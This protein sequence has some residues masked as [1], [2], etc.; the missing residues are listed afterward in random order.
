MSTDFL[1][2]GFVETITPDFGTLS[3]YERPV[4]WL[5]L[6]VITSADQ[7]FVGL[8]AV[9]EEANFAAFVANGA[10]TVDWGDGTVENYSAGATALHEYDY[11]N[12]ALNGSLCSRGYKQAVVIITP[13]AGQTLS[14]LNLFI[15]HTQ[16]GLQGYTSG[17]LDIAVAGTSISSLVISSA[18]ST[19]R[20]SLL[21]QVAIYQ[22]VITTWAN[23][24]YNCH[25]LRS[26]PVLYTNSGTDFSSMFNGCYALLTVPLFNTANGT[27]F[28]QTFYACRNLQEV[29][30]LN[31]ANGLNFANTFQN[32]TNLRRVGAWDTSKGTTFGGM[33]QGCNALLEAPMLNTALGTE[34]GSM[35]QNCYSL[36]KVPVYNTA[37]G[38]NFSQMFGTCYSLR[39]APALNTANGTQFANM[40]VNCYSLLAVPLLDTA[41]GL[42]FGSMFSSCYRL[43]EIPALNTS[44]GNSF[45][46][47]FASC[48]GLRT[49]PALDFS[50]ATTLLS[51]FS[52]CEALQNIPAIDSLVCTTLGSAFNLCPS[53]RAIPALNCG[54]LTSSSGFNTTFSSSPQISRIEAYNI[55]YSLSVA[56]LKLSR[57][58]LEEVMRNLVVTTGQT[59]TIS[60][61]YGSATAATS[62][63]GTTT[64]GSNT[65]AMASTSGLAVG[66]CVAGTG[67]PTT[68]NRTVTADPATNAIARTAHGYSGNT[69]VVFTGP[70]SKS[71]GGTLPSSGVWSLAHGAG[72]TLAVRNGSTAAA[73]STDN[74]ATWSSKTLP[75]SASWRVAYGLGLFVLFATSGTAYYTSPDGETWTTRALSVGRNWAVL[76]FHNGRF[77]GLV[78]SSAVTIVSTNGTSWSESSNFPHTG[79]AYQL[80]AGNGLF[81]ALVIGTTVSSYATSTDGVTWVSRTLPTSNTLCCA[82]GNGAFLV[83]G[84]TGAVA[85]LTVDGILWKACTVPG[86]FA[87]FAALAFI[88]GVFYAARSTAAADVYTSEDGVMWYAHAAPTSTAW[89][90]A[91]AG[92]DAVVVVAGSGTASMKIAASVL[93]R[94]NSTYY[95]VEITTDAF[96]LA[97]SVGGSAID[98]GTSETS[99]DGTLRAG[100]VIDSIVTNT[101]VTLSAPAVASGTNTLSFR[102]L[103]VVH[104]LMR[105]WTV[106]G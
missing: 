55:K 75:A 19:M 1:M 7:K 83:L 96:K 45:S 20:H 6:P 98:I 58:R 90:L 25:S 77:V 18:S 66:M 69:P 78:S 82:Y 15:K 2:H 80:F 79:N 94:P 105:G 16:S 74:G 106:T 32:C 51:L 30:L 34:F 93:P 76:T 41:N 43:K 50:N 4:D 81:M 13:Q 44:K 91:I 33:F 28:N 97:T 71:A 88:N 68:T 60:N 85:Y 8:H 65:V 21:E 14:T 23:K 26:L 70:M 100:A 29:P 52:G 10:I 47:M 64:D 5:A 27:T 61:N 56:T 22:N 62:L 63:S 53:L 3:A 102:L 48:M 99:L 39:L 84:R 92:S 72:I 37:L 101:S 31:T 49:I 95:P 24:F 57:T 59:L 104:A 36:T 87:D 35:F 38:T 11:N 86:G 40:F 12:V 103:N 67:L 89:G 54:S 17:W 42:N 73:I 46:T 9:H